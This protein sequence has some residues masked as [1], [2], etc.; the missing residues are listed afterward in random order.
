MTT[1]TS[2]PPSTFSVTVWPLTALM[3]PILRA[4]FSGGAGCWAAARTVAVP[5]QSASAAAILSFRNILG[6]PMAMSVYRESRKIGDE[7]EEKLP[8]LSLGTIDFIS[9]LMLPER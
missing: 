8:I 1:F 5:A 9:T 7:T 3:V 2:A 6:L 4:T